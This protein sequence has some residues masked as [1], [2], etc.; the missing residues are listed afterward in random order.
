MFACQLK[1]SALQ[2]NAGP[3]I[4]FAVAWRCDTRRNLPLYELRLYPAG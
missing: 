4:V 3:R 2:R 1:G